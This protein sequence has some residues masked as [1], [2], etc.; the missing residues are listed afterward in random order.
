MKVKLAH[1]HP[2]RVLRKNKARQKLIR[3]SRILAKGGTQKVQEQTDTL[4]LKALERGSSV[5]RLKNAQVARALCGFLNPGPRLIYYWLVVVQYRGNYLTQT[6]K[7]Q[8][9]KSDL[10]VVLMRYTNRIS[11][12]FPIIPLGYKRILCR[13][14]FKIAKI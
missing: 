2:Y 7:P 12:L 6:S 8:R 5:F 3:P 4:Y 13:I 1:E 11:K 10:A 9:V 14:P